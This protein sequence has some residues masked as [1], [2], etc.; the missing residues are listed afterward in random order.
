MLDP[1]IATFL[2]ERQATWLKDKLKPCKTEA[3]Q[4]DVESTAKEKFSLANWL[5]DAAKRAG[6]L[7][8]VSHPGK[9]THPST[10][11]SA[12]IA[13][14]QPKPD[15][16]LRTG[17][18]HADFDVFG[19]AAALDVYKFLSLELTNGQS[20][21]AHLEQDSETIKAQFTLPNILFTE[22]QQDLLA[23]KQ[24]SCTV[25]T[26]EKIK[27]VYFP[28]DDDY[29]L[30]SILT[31]SGLMFKLKQRINE[32]RF[33]EAAKQARKDRHDQ[34]YSELG[35]DDI[36]GL[37]VIGFGGTK[38]QNISVLNNQNGGTAYLLPSMPPPLKPRGL[39][40]P[41]N[42]FFNNSLY[43]KNYQDSFKSLHKLLVT[44]HNNLNIREGRDKWLVS[45]IEQALNDQII[46]K[47]W[48]LRQLD[49]GWS[50]N[51]ALEQHQKIW[52]DNTNAEQREAEDDWLNKVV[53]DFARWIV[54]AYIKIIGKE[55]AI[56]LG[57]DELN[58]IKQLIAAYQEDLR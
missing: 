39:Q 33:S 54:Y 27:Q 25:K 29:H 51:T 20:V 18:A 36:Y 23:I 28:V 13:K 37:T 16:F 19:N 50:A 35:F 5:P 32:F 15:G 46:E 6:Q 1:A 56:L 2:A 12:I 11:T 9:F 53:A 21:L 45:I 38:P 43:Y 41:K 44:E 40:I 42:D 49:T 34:K 3:E 58:H 26:S 47:L 22:L 17:N 57:D 7:A 24:A 55:K 4:Q 31:P 10:K 52:L 8:M 48:Q 30:L 14:C